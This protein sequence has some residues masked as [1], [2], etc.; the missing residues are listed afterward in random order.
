MDVPL[1]GDAPTPKAA[2]A[3]ARPSLLMQVLTSAFL[4]ILADIYA[5]RS[6]AMGRVGS[7]SSL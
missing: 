3:A 6:R 2:A 1:L 4:T 5:A 7:R